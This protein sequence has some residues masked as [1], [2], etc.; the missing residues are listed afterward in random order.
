MLIYVLLNIE[1]KSKH[2]SVKG[3]PI[4]TGSFCFLFLIA[5]VDVGS[6][7]Y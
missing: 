4:C 6:R 2:F 3:V 1:K 7:M 5:L